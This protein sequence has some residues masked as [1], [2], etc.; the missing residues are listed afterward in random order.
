MSPV[1]IWIHFSG[2]A[3]LSCSEVISTA[4]YSCWKKWPN[5]KP[6]IAWNIEVCGIRWHVNKIVDEVWWEYILQMSWEACSKERNIEKKLWPWWVL[7]GSSK[8]GAGFVQLSSKECKDA[9]YLHRRCYAI[10][11]R[12]TNTKLRL[13][14]PMNSANL[15]CWNVTCRTDKRRPACLPEIKASN[16]GRLE[17]IAHTMHCVSLLWSD[18]PEEHAVRLSILRI[19]HGKLVMMAYVSIIK[20]VMVWGSLCRGESEN[21]CQPWKYMETPLSPHVTVASL[22]GS[23]RSCNAIFGNAP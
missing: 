21:V 6:V 2:R 23:D 4:S 15:A 20:R 8:V 22:K 11:L 1:C 16:L 10:F 14:A 13:G 12:H 19:C 9:Q 3:S 18:W 17:V 5:S 7:F